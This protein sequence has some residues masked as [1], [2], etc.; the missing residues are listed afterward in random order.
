[1][2]QIKNIQA[3]VVCDNI[4]AMNV[5]A[6]MVPQ[7]INGA[8]FGGGCVGGTLARSGA[9]AG[10]KEYAAY[11]EKNKL[12][13]GDAYMTA[14]GGGSAKYLL[15]LA[16]VGCEADSSFACTITAVCKALFLT[17]EI[18]LKT[19]A[20]PAVGSGII[21]TLTLEQFAK[22]IFKAVT[23]FAE[24]AKSVQT[25]TMVVYGTSAAPAQEVLE[26]ESYLTAD[27]QPGQKEFN[28]AEWLEGF[29]KDIS[30]ED[31]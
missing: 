24:R 17:D 5:D 31:R 3:Q 28:M 9:Y 19:V 22:A 26:S 10:M 21:G 16:T 14:T 12:S 8:S 1:M 23:H 4:A 27:D 6:V 20:I 25:V 18:G 15:H 2:K 11:A 7:F 30:G 29:A 13:Y